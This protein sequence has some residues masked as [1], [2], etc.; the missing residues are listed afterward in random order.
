[1]YML[2]YTCA[3]FV[4][5]CGWVCVLQLLQGEKAFFLRYNKLKI[6]GEKNKNFSSLNVWTVYI[7]VHLGKTHQNRKEKHFLLQYNDCC[8]TSLVYL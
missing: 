4:C 3:Y 8:L 7:N 1:M 6:V 5:M 2:V